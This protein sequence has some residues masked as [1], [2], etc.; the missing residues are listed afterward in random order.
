MS[1]PREKRVFFTEL[2][3]YDYYSEIIDYDGTGLPNYYDVTGDNY[4]LT[5]QYL[6]STG[7]GN[8]RYNLE[9]AH[10]NFAAYAWV[11]PVTATKFGISVR[12]NGV[13]PYMLA[14]FDF[15]NNEAGMYQ[16]GGLGP[17]SFNEDFNFTMGR[18]YMFGLWAYEND[19]YYWIN[20]W[21]LGHL[22]ALQPQAKSFGIVTYE[23][24]LE[25]HLMRVYELADPIDPSRE[26]E[27]SNTLVQYRKFLQGALAEVTEQNWNAYKLAH[28]RYRFCRDIGAKNLSWE[29]MGY[30]VP[31]PST[32]AFFNDAS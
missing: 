31:K 23:G 5:T 22:T 32:D 3:N 2:F 15:E 14:E 27:T 26:D 11:R 12:N 4:S 10:N 20:D 30:P 16:V 13:D 29:N 28:S 8:L 9:F 7:A 18:F 1:L 21:R 6:K 24:E 19:F 25:V 17:T